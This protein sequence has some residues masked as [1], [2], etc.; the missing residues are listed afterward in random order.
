MATSGD[1]GEERSHKINFVNA[2]SFLVFGQSPCSKSA[3]DNFRQRR[4]HGTGKEACLN[5]EEVEAKFV[6]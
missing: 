2:E 3:E 1:G 5:V 4:K 6:V